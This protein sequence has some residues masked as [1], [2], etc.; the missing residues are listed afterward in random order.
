[1][2]DIHERERHRSDGDLVRALDD[3]LSDVEERAVRAHLESC[4]ECRARMDALAEETQAFAAWMR[5][6]DADAMPDQLRRARARTAV[7]DAAAA[8]RATAHG[9]LASAGWLRAA[10]AVLVVA[11]VTATVDPLRA[12]VV[13]RWEALSGVAAAPAPVERL[14]AAAT[15]AGSVV[16]FQTP[17]PVFVLEMAAA[18]ER[19]AVRLR[20]DDVEQAQAQTVGEGE[21]FLV[22]PSGLK[23]E[24]TPASRADYEVVLPAGTEFIQVFVGGDP[25][26]LMEVPHDIELPWTYTVPLQ[27]ER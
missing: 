3:Q 17:G 15:E 24:N 9:G 25:V 21:S 27:P 1:M 4:A 14:P 10:A 12:W 19:G 8:Q 11:L 26:A 22:L 23:V 5:W 6:L 16:S 13:D 18:Q 2:N 7:R 20:I